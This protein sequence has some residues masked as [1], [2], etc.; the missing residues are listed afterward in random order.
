MKFCRWTLFEVGKAFFCE[1]MKDIF[2]A[3][4]LGFDGK[5]RALTHFV[6]F[7]LKNIWPMRR[8]FVSQNR[9]E[10]SCCRRCNSLQLHGENQLRSGNNNI[11]R[12][13]PKKNL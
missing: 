2:E 9:R 3:N 7:E 11:D 6:A 10:V 13:S 12:Y 5:S 8:Y 1:E 4:K